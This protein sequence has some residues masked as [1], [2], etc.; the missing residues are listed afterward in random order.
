MYTQLGRAVYTIRDPN[1]CSPERIFDRTTVRG[2]EQTVKRRADGRSRAAQLYHKNC[3]LSIGNLHKFLNFFLGI[4]YII[5]KVNR[6]F[7][8][9]FSNIFSEIAY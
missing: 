5:L 8:Q 6:Q 1:G 9:S 4:S 2:A 3:G 7:A